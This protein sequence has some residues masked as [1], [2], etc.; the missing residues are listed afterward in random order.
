MMR[1]LVLA[2]LLTIVLG[3]SGFA[4]NQG[5]V[6]RAIP[7]PDTLGANFAVSDNSASPFT[8]TVGKA[9]TTNTVASS[10]N[11]ALVGDPVTFTA[12]ISALAPGSG[13]PSGT[14]TFMDGT[15]V[16]GTTNLVQG[17]TNSTAAFTTSSLLVGSHAIKAIYNDLLDRAWS[18]ARARDDKLPPDVQKDIP[19]TVPGQQ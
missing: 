12:T 7:L 15:N 3:A 13:I 1:R 11:P 4:Q 19:P 14:A 5:S 2:A 6:P 8:Q 16:L 10:S 9:S 17:V 18:E